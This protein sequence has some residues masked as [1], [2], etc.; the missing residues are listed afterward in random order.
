MVGAGRLPHTRLPQSPEP[1]PEESVTQIVDVRCLLKER[2]CRCKKGFV[3]L[4]LMALVGMV[5]WS[6]RD[7]PA[8]TGHR[9]ELAHDFVAVVTEES[10]S[11][12]LLR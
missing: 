4:L 11:A 7:L 6:S 9:V 8:L 2:R 3:G 5:A 1:E 12:A 10:L